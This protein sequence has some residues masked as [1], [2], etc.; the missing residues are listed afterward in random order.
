MS[1][2]LRPLFVKGK[3]CVQ[4]YEGTGSGQVKMRS[5]D[6]FGRVLGMR[7][8]KYLVRNRILAGK[9]SPALIGGEYLTLQKDF[10]LG[11]GTE[12]RT[13]FRTLS[14]R[15]RS[16]IEESAD[17]RNGFVVREARKEIKKLKTKITTETEAHR[18]R[19][20]KN[21]AHGKA[22]G[23]QVKVDHKE[24]LVFWQ[25]K[26]TTMETKKAQQVQQQKL[27]LANMVDIHKKEMGRLR[28]TLNQ[29]ILK[30]KQE[31]VSLICL[32]FISFLY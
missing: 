19:S 17:W 9:G 22:V 14:K 10:G 1:P 2:E 16:R 4:V 3:D 18:D 6:W 30:L 28:T 7:E 21:A 24:Q 31:K 8:G 12:E 32:S 23:D 29:Q 27:A 13:H 26:C 25:N 15:T 5:V 20:E 11:V